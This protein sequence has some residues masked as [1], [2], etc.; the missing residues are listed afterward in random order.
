MNSSARQIADEL[1]PGV[2]P[3]ADP[4]SLREAARRARAL[5]E[6][7]ER[8]TDV[9]VSAT[10][11]YAS[12]AIGGVAVEGEFG[13]ATVDGLAQI[14]GA[15]P[16]SLPHVAGRLRVMAASLESFADVVVE[17]EQQMTTIALVADR[18][19]RR[20]EVFAEVGDDSWRVSAS[21]A[22]RLALTAAGD[23]YTQRSEEAGQSAGGTPPAATSGMMPFAPMGALGGAGA[24]GAGLGAAG[25]G[26]AIGAAGSRAGRDTTGGDL[27][28]LR[29]RAENLQASVP[30]AIAGWFRT[31]VGVGVGA[32]GRR[33]VV[34]GTNDP[35]PY[36]RAGLELADDEA[37]TAN[38][39]APELAIVEHM[40][41]SGIT[42][43]AIA[44]AT[45]ME[46]ATLSALRAA[47]IVAVG[48]GSRP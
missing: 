17:T 20:A 37:L 30:P 19:R 47:D 22:G 36:Q 35:Q 14:T 8:V 38:G 11:A 18:D 43:T 45:P 28:W 7:V 39:R 10:A 34:V 27:T 15:G 48:P 42:P 3:G 46:S 25:L 5:A 16:D 26:A 13:D 29:R 6:S 31:A 12:P 40:T 33:V 2:W 9:V 32:R 24:L 1:A 41:A 21:S 44:A 4:V 23:D